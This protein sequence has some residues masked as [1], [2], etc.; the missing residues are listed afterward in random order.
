LL[1][2]HKED[3]KRGSGKQERSHR[4]EFD[5]VVLDVMLPGKDVLR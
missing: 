3:S 2:G 5:A 1:L 4:E